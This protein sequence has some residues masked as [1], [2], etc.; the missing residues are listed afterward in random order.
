MDVLDWHAVSNVLNTFANRGTRPLPERDIRTRLITHV[1]FMDRVIIPSQSL[2]CNPATY[3]WVIDKKKREL[4]EWLCRNGKLVVLSYKERQS[5]EELLELLQARKTVALKWM[6]NKELEKVAKELDS[7]FSNKKY[8]L[9]TNEADINKSKT[10]LSFAFINQ[11]DRVHPGLASLQTELVREAKS[12]INNVGVIHGSWWNTLSQRNRLFTPFDVVLKEI[13]TIV[14]DSAHASTLERFLIGH[15]YHRTAFSL[16]KL[17]EQL[18]KQWEVEIELGVYDQRDVDSTIFLRDVIEKID[19]QILE[20]LEEETKEVRQE[21]FNSI[22]KLFKHPSEDNLR[23][24]KCRMDDYIDILGRY[25]RTT[26]LSNYI[27]KLR[28]VKRIESSLRVWQCIDSVMCSLCV[29]GAAYGISEYLRSEGGFMGLILTFF[30]SSTLLLVRRAV[31]RKEE[32]MK[33]EI[34]KQRAELDRI[35]PVSFAIN[36]TIQNISKFEI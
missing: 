11:I 14:F 30:G 21:Y 19:A 12:E 5:F 26:T 34:S 8:R 6:R 2:L 7:I 18:V 22:S 17:T 33:K 3:E 28:A 16:C 20:L 1:L 4:F 35:R 25:I 24:V 10:Q 15:P 32:R 13:G 31:K 36:T 27:K 9:I 23:E 29:G